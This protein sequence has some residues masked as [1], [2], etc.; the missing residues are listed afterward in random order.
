[1][2]PLRQSLPLKLLKAREAVMD[3]FRPHLHQANVTEQ[4]WRVIRALAENDT[5]DAGKLARMVTL[6]M[7]SLSRILRD[8]EQRGLI[9]KQRSHDDRRLVTASITRSGRRLFNKMSQESEVIYAQIVED[10]GE[11]YFLDL[12][13]RLDEVIGILNGTTA[14]DK[15]SLKLPEKKTPP[16]A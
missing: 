13:A 14:P 7:P 16:P 6:R 2:R 15:Q 4:Q 5:L 10:L 8:L 9:T 12:M 1:M 11:D 3:R